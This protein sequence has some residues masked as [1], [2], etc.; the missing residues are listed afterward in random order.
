MVWFGACISS[1][2]YWISA[3]LA[4]AVCSVAPKLFN[5]ICVPAL[6][7]PKIC[8][9]VRSGAQ[10]LKRVRKG[11]TV[12]CAKGTRAALDKQK[13]SVKELVVYSSTNNSS[14]NIN[15]ISVFGKGKTLIKLMA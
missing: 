15:K 2:G 1:W 11:L 13:A 9:L 8:P 6:V 14:S 5:L 4:G 10:T 12:N 3:I 7:F